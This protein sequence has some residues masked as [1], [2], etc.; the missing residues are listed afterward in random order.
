MKPKFKK[1]I[2]YLFFSGITY[3]VF[4]NVYFSRWDTN[5]TVLWRQHE[6]EKFVTKLIVTLTT[7][8]GD[9]ETQIFSFA[10]N[11]FISKYNLLKFP[12]EATTRYI[13]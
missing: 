12:L 10:C 7:V 9:H 2:K 5:S 8:V 3:W 4:K 6:L 13:D 11:V 1:Y